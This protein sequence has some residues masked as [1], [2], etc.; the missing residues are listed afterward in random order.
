MTTHNIW[1]LR[2]FLHAADISGA[3]LPAKHMISV[4]NRFQ[5]FCERWK[6]Q[7]YWDF[8]VSVC[9][10]PFIPSLPF[11]WALKIPLYLTS[12]PVFLHGL[13]LAP[14]KAIL[15]NRKLSISVLLHQEWGSI[16]QELSL[17]EANRSMGT[18]RQLWSFTQRK[19]RGPRDGC[20]LP[21]LGPAFRV[22]NIE[23]Y[24]KAQRPFVKQSYTTSWPPEV[25]F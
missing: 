18:K 14:Y 24:P 10:S 20:F 8:P 22:C 23:P 5:F 3:V 11:P 25:F 7:L 17:I 1:G 19:D 2:S 15:L 4:R 9:S 21:L 16:A 12:L 6:D 13:A